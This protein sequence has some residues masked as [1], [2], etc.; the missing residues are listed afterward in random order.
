LGAE[1]APDGNS[2]EEYKKLLAAL[3]KWSAQIKAGRLT[4]ND[5]WHAMSSTIWKTF[6]YSLPATTLSLE[7]CKKIMAPELTSGMK[8][9]HICRNFPKDLIDG[10]ASEL[11]G[12]IPQLHNLQGILHIEAVIGNSGRKGIT[13]Q[14][15]KASMEALILE[16]GVGE[17]ITD[18]RLRKMVEGS[19]SSWMG[20]TVYFMMEN[21]LQLQHDIVLPL[22]CHRDQYITKAFALNRA[23]T[24]D[25][26]AS[27]RC[28]LCLKV[29]CFSEICTGSGDLITEDAWLGHRGG[30]INE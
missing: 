8:H 15:A 26:E 21:R 30:V 24:C 23:T 29:V 14:L 3:K 25:L 7:Q 5:A 27:I 10:P 2:E 12:G 18:L 16:M 6:K 13:G 9:R 20:F 28:R 1:T 22:Y 11:G 19:T 17:D 4:K